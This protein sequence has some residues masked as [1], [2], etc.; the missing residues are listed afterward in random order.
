VKPS[1]LYPGVDFIPRARRKIGGAAGPL[2]V[3]VGDKALLWYLLAGT[4]GGPSRIRLLEELVEGPAN[5]NQLAMALGVDYRT[6]RHHLRILEKNGL[7]VCLVGH[8][9]AAPYELSAQLRVQFEKVLE[10]RDAAALRR[11][12]SAT[13]RGRGIRGTS[14]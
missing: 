1:A 10:V 8:P 7:I 2:T 6:V 4:R 9:Y 3:N 12:R 14:P 13:R 5:A 11:Q